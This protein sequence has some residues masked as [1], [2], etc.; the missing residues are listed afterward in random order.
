[1]SNELEIRPQTVAAV[2]SPGEF[3]LIMKQAD[4]ISRSGIVPKNYQSVIAGDGRMLQ[5]KRANVVVATL[6]GRTFG[7]DALTAMRNIHII[8][9]AASL[10]PEAM[11]GMI[12][13]AGHSVSIK[14]H[15]DGVTVSARR[16]DTGDDMEVTF[17][18]ADAVRANLCTLKD[19]QPYA[20]SDKGKPLPWEQYPIDMCQWRAAAAIA[21]GLFGDIVLGLGYTPDELGAL[22][23]AEG[24]VII[25]SAPM[26]APIATPTTVEPVPETV[27]AELVTDNQPSEAP[28]QSDGWEG[29]PPVYRSEQQSKHLW[30]LMRKLD[31]NDR[32]EALAYI[33]G[34]VGRDVESTKTLSV[35]EASV[36]IDA[37]R[38][39][40][41]V[42][43]NID[44]VTGEVR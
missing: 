33:S 35:S 20:R 38:K 3:D 29:D 27:E 21:R 28:Q 1:M 19:G 9:G 42:A 34:I 24:E 36:V 5:D 16:R 18:Y 32:D 7:W 31:M 41:S 39:A 37:L 17:T 6:T 8:E 30:T 14:R 12:R 10:K 2:P 43:E 11:L 26:P 15:T 25:E 40:D 22:V 4:I 44:T 23:D 13:K